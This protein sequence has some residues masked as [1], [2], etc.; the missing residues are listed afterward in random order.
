MRSLLLQITAAI[1]ETLAL[2]DQSRDRATVV[3]I[4]LLHAVEPAIVN[5]SLG[6][7][8]SHPLVVIL[9]HYHY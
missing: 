7:D 3:L 2:I 6:V 4:H 9:S 1:L 5:E 8:V